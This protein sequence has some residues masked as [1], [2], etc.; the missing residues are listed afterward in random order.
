M[1]G[2][3]DRKELL[4]YEASEGG[5]GVL[6]LL[7]EDPKAIAN[8]AR[9]ALEVCHYDPD[10]LQEKAGTQCG[11]ACY[12]CLLDYGNQ[13]DHEH[14]DRSKIKDLLV[15]LMNATVKGAGGAGSREERMAA[16]R[17]Q[18]DS[19]LEHR[20]LDFI[21]S[22][23]LKPPSHAQYRIPD[24]RTQPD[25]YY[26]ETNAAIYVDGPVHDRPDL[27]REDQ[28]ITDRLMDNGYIV[29]RFHHAADWNAIVAK[30]P[31]VFGEPHKTR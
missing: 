12:E 6:R 31:D 18:C 16:L 20:W 5:A 22:L 17:K 15:E 21:D 9:H 23:L 1:P 14:L 28:E 7:V 29:I 30:H 13:L 19:K 24:M 11:K 4:F 10:T 27:I 25:F 3:A 2:P 26:K 8:L